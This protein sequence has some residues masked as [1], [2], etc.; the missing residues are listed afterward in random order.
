MAIRD[1]PT[2]IIA[3]LLRD[4]D[5]S[6]RNYADA[7]RTAAN[8]LLL[9]LPDRARVVDILK[10]MWC[11][12]NSSS[13]LDDGTPIAAWIE[14]HADD[15][16]ISAIASWQNVK[17][18]NGAL[19][20]LAGEAVAQYV[21]SERP[22]S[23]SVY[24]KLLGALTW[25]G[26]EVLTSTL[27]AKIEHDTATR[28]CLRIA[29]SSWSVAADDWC[30]RRR[31]DR[32]A[33]AALVSAWND[34]RST[35][36]VR[37]E[38]IH[39][40]TWTSAAILIDILR[41]I[42][43]SEW[44]AFVE[45]LPLRAVAEDVVMA[46][47]SRDDVDAML[48]RLTQVP[49][50]AD[51]RLHAAVLILVHQLIAFPFRV[52]Q[53]LESEER[54][55]SGEDRT[56]QVSEALQAFDGWSST[57]VKRIAKEIA[58]RPDGARI[59]TAFSAHQLE[60]AIDFS[61]RDRISKRWISLQL[62]TAI[63]FGRMM[64]DI[65]PDLLTN[66]KQSRFDGRLLSVLMRGLLVR[67]DDGTGIS[68]ATGGELWNA[69]LD[70]LSA[71]ANGAA[72]ISVSQNPLDT[73]IVC[74]L[75]EIVTS[76]SDPTVRW[77]EAWDRLASRRAINRRKPVARDNT[78]SEI[79]LYIGVIA[80]VIQERSTTATDLWQL[81]VNCAIE[82]ESMDPY[83]GQYGD[84]RVLVRC[85]A[86]AASTLKD[87]SGNLR[88]IVNYSVPDPDLTA[89]IVEILCQNGVSSQAVLSLFGDGC[90]DSVRAAKAW[91]RGEGEVDRF[92]RL[93]KFLET[94]HGSL[95]TVPNAP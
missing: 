18:G 43:A 31:D 20:I 69:W 85:A 8:R 21:I 40:P 91:V 32:S 59:L 60:D 52:L 86:V 26:I 33:I 56:R 27:R 95:T 44:L 88:K 94:G 54:T 29:L 37:D 14:S 42:S 4:W 76:T 93:L 71:D 41:T 73:W 39:V 50:S 3:T 6:R 36:A 83:A 90:I 46:S 30:I 67:G 11:A 74:L 47:V 87:P 12:P 82:I 75:A 68:E 79:L 51:S 65:P 1:D 89:R 35:P 84:W 64:G 9:S 58:S 2:E 38:H 22:T 25:E 81:V 63:E 78:T 16:W 53:N 72:T 7:E 57:L 62:R 17:G 48:L 92:E 61:I 66:P 28:E 23:W 5:K 10:V 13:E 49:A 45:T 34:A 80:V 24:R 70:V 77:Q 19:S 15:P 55:A